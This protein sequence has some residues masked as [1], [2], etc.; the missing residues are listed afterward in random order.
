M[1]ENTDNDSERYHEYARQL[2]A[3]V[4]ETL[5]KFKRGEI[6]ESEVF[7]LA[8]NLRNEQLSALE[9]LA[10]PKDLVD[11]TAWRKNNPLPENC[12]PASYAAGFMVGLQSIDFE[13][14]RHAIHQRLNDEVAKNGYCKQSFDGGYIDGKHGLPQAPKSLQ[15]RKRTA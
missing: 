8:S 14:D 1:A 9:P 13:G 15:R 11:A 7:T 2:T 4:R 3:L 5:A 6:T 12:D 10:K